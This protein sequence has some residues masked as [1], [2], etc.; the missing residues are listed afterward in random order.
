MNRPLCA[1]VVAAL[2]MLPGSGT[3]DAEERPAGQA[4]EA[5]SPIE[6][7]YVLVPGGRIFYEAQGR[8]PAIVLIHD[9]ILHRE[10]WDAQFEAL[11]KEHRVIRWDR[12]GYGKSDPPREPYSNLDDLRAVMDKNKTSSAT[13]VGCS[14]GGLLALQFSLENPELV[15]AMVLAGPI[16]SGLPLSDHF[17]ARG[18]R[19]V[20]LENAPVEQRIEY[21]TSKDPWLIAPENAAARAKA[22]ALLRA[23]P[24][25]LKVEWDLMRW[26]DQPALEQL[27][28]I[29]VPTLLLVG[30]ADIP[31]VHAHTGAIEA[32]I[33]GA[34]RVVLAHAGHLAHLEVPEAFNAEVLS[35]LRG[36]KQPP[37]PA[38]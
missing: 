6:S 29:A 1:A 21:Y 23:N 32:G 30:E 33:K 24:Q 28:K 20:P 22:R 36:L 17:R 37:Q 16:V 9:G 14:L 31:D 19:G 4:G 25:N 7:G 8:G 2:A 35:F 3:A 26:P 5:A 15:T 12:R 34:K 27:G 11:S 18:G 38:R 10:T 13:L